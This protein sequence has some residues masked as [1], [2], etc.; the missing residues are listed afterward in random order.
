ML[1]RALV[2]NPSLLTYDFHN[3]MK[4]V[5]ALYEEIGISGHDLSAML[6]SRPTL[7]PT[8]SFKEEKM[9][10]IKDDNKL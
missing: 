6:I 7:I 5:I 4:P 10:H 8:T 9:K 3:T 2:R 1:R